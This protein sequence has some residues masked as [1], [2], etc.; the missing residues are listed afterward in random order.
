M[1]R[2]THGL[3]YTHT[4][5]LMGD[6]WEHSGIME[7]GDTHG[8]DKRPETRGDVNF[9]NKSGSSNTTQT[10]PSTPH[11]VVTE[12]PL[13]WPAP[14]GPGWSF[15]KSVINDLS[16]MKRDG[17]HCRSSGPYPSQSTR[18]CLPLPRLR[19]ASNLLTL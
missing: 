10:E 8:K 14:D 19:T 1:T 11:Y 7:T 9:Q 18:Y 3:I 12:S 15:S 17:T 16:R 6:R 5:R 13:R 4:I 2:G